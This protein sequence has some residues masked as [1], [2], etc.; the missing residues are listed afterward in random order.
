[1]QVRWCFF[2]DSKGNFLRMVLIG[3]GELKKL[4][5]AALSNLNPSLAH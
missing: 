2:D 4:L 3:I 5:T 1:M